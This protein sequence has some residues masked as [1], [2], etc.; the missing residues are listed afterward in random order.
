MLDNK[1][2]PYL[3]ALIDDESPTTRRAVLKELSAYGKDLDKVFNSLTPPPPE[4]V[5]RK[6]QELLSHYLYNEKGNHWMDWLNEEDD[7]LR[8]E[9]AVTFLSSF[10][11]G[12]YD[13]ENI[14]REIQELAAAFLATGV[15]INIFELSNFLF[16]TLGYSGEKESY[17]DPK[18]NDVSYVLKH[19]KGLPISLA[20]IYMLIG[21][22]LGLTIEGFNYPGH[23]MAKSEVNGISYLIDCF[24]NGEIFK[25]NEFLSA[26]VSGSLDSNKKLFKANSKIIVSR[27]LRNL[28]KAYETT[29][30][31]LRNRQVVDFLKELGN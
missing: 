11:S 19:K 27:M 28:A 16:M 10:Q 12:F 29:G 31:N 6:V 7:Y 3:L 2:I 20:V 1:Q 24:N 13:S 8:L 14:K 26:N 23:F 17:Y 25:E 9:K 21:K 4:S 18:N 15:D 30:D 5:R 22:E